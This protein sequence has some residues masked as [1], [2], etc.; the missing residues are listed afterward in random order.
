MHDF[1]YSNQ[2]AVYRN[3]T[4]ALLNQ[5]IFQ[6]VPAAALP[7][8]LYVGQIPLDMTDAVLT[9]LLEVIACSCLQSYVLTVVFWP[10]IGQSV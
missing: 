8:T 1:N 2:S 7:L 6:Q 4:C 10:Y 3:H 5:H 9:K